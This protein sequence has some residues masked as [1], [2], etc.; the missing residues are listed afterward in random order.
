[1]RDENR[2]HA[3]LVALDDAQNL[4]GVGARIDNYSVER[5]RIADDVAIT[6]QHPD[7]KNFVN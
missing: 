4:L 5:F 2:G 6:L 1:M 3:Q 7:R